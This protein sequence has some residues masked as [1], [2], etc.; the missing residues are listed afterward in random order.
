MDGMGNEVTGFAICPTGLDFFGMIT[1]L[2]KMDPKTSSLPL[3]HQFLVRGKER[4]NIVTPKNTQKPTGLIAFLPFQ[5]ISITDPYI[6]LPFLF[7]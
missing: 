5:T 4:F 7:S 1:D 2:G 3:F 6:Y